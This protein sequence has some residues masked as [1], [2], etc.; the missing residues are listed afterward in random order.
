MYLQNGKYFS[1][2]IKSNTAKKKITD[3]NSKRILLPKWLVRGFREKNWGGRSGERK[4]ES[5]NS[6]SETDL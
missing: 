5:L 4:K 1:T 6:L 3:V 2:A